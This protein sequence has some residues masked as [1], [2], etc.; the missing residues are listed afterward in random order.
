MG[1][2]TL[3]LIFCS[4]YDQPKSKPLISVIL[5]VTVDLSLV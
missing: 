2:S 5:I 4:G 1:H 3:T